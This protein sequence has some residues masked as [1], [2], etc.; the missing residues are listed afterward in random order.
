MRLLWYQTV[1]WCPQHLPCDSE[2]W[3]G[4]LEPEAILNSQIHSKERKNVLLRTDSINDW[5]ALHSTTQLCYA[6]NFQ[7]LLVY[8]T[9]DTRCDLL[10]SGLEV[11]FQ[12]VT[13][14]LSHSITGGSDGE[15]FAFNVGDLSLLPGSRRSPGE[16]NAYPHQ[17][18]YLEDSMDRGAWQATV[19]VVAKSWI[20]LS[21]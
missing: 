11:R 20:W 9:H 19:H 2:E 7:A 14:I 6:R 5:C 18:S 13:I 8:S 21:N 1:H 3:P 15:E 4:K 17:N 16:G 10:D 12:P